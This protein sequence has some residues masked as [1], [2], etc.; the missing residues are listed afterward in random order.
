[1]CH[2]GTARDTITNRLHECKVFPPGTAGHLPDR[3]T[4]S[5]QDVFRRSTSS[6]TGPAPSHGS[7]TSKTPGLGLRAGLDRGEAGCKPEYKTYRKVR[8]A[9]TTHTTG[10]GVKSG[11][12]SWGGGA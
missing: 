5:A 1:M 6:E 10:R 7:T 12:I 4:S 2:G 9:P 8:T 3:E 11:M